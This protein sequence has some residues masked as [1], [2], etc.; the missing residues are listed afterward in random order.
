MPALRRQEGRILGV[1]PQ[2]SKNTLLLSYKGQSRSGHQR[3][4]HRLLSPGTFGED[5]G[6]ADRESRFPAVGTPPSGSQGEGRG[7]VEHDAA[8]ADRPEHFAP[9]R[10]EATASADRRGIR[11]RVRTEWT[12]L[13][14]WAGLA[15]S[16]VGSRTLSIV[17]PLLA[18]SV[19][20]SPV[21]AGW[22]GF[23]LT[24][25][26]L[27]FYIPAGVVVDRLNPRSLILVTET[28][29][30]LAAVSVAIAAL[31]GLVTLPHIMTAAFVEGSLWVLHSLGETA[32]IR[33]L[34]PRGNLSGML[35][36]SET[37]THLAVLTARPLGGFLIGVGT[38]TPFLVTTAL[39]L[40]SLLSVPFL[41]VSVLS[42]RL[43][44]L[45]L[46]LSVLSRR[47]AA[48]ER[49]GSRSSPGATGRAERRTRRPFL[50]E[51][52]DGVRELG[53]HPFLRH[54]MALTT[55][56][57]LMANALIMI[58]I[59]GSAALPPFQVGLVLA[60]SGLGGALAAAL[61]PAIR[62]LRPVV[63]LSSGNTVL[64]A[65]MWIWAVALGIAF[66]GGH[67]LF[68]G[69]A[70]LLIGCT[71]ALSNV[72]IRTY[73]LRTVDRFKLAR[74][75]S[76]HRL[77]AHGAVCL[78]AP[79]GALLVS[80]LGRAGSVMGLFGVMLALALTVTVAYV[81]RICLPRRNIQE[82]AGT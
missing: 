65:Q 71:G 32:L 74:V 62:R 24:L 44:V 80:T 72:A 38:A 5:N 56:T 25:P 40:I 75:V 18:L 57:N 63:L 61:L 50:H 21:H 37:S 7:V 53:G 17:Y 20:G 66:F 45:S 19:T 78:A 2:N 14:I 46:R 55:V 48:L 67:T 16:A 28:V 35:A 52:I 77:T 39:F 22:A 29:R 13:R 1:S 23:A 47:L 26:T 8:Q 33:S 10:C 27:L 81:L 79:L 49:E 68:F 11:L 31:L 60:A 30:G 6:R 12:L 41:R 34:V 69:L 43:S 42:L 64:F 9:R 59:A 36:T 3:L 51:V 82:T 54:A 58:F 76:L 15:S 4:F 70:T 73:E